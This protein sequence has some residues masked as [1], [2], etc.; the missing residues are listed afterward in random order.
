[1]MGIETLWPQIITVLGSIIVA[2][3][4]V[5]IS[6]R[7]QDEERVASASESNVDTAIKLKK[8]MEEE[9]TELKRRCAAMEVEIARQENQIDDMR[10]RVQILSQYAEALFEQIEDIGIEAPVVPLAKIRQIAREVSDE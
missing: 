10:R 8:W 6:S 2:Y 1:M 4:T 9:I 5:K 7:G 3:L